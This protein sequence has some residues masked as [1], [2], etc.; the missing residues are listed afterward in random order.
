MAKLEKFREISSALK[1]SY[2]DEW[3]KQGRKIIGY[4]CTYAPEEI[5][6]AA[7]I[8]PY[9]IRGVTCTD[10]SNAD[11]YMARF[12]CSFCR[13]VLELG[14]TGAYDFLDGFCYL[15]GCDHIRRVYDNWVKLV[16]IPFNH[17]LPVPHI[18]SEDGFNYYMEGVKGFKEHIEQHFDMHITDEKLRDSIRVYNESRELLEKLYEF[19]NREYPPVTGA[20]SLSIVAASSAMPRE[21]FNILLG[22]VLKELENMD[23]IRDYDARL[24]IVGSELD[25]PSLIELIED[26]GGL[27]VT[28][29][30]CFGTRQF[31]G[32]VSE[33]G[34]P[35]EAIV[36]RYYEHNPCPR[37]LREYPK[38]LGFV[39]EMAEKFKVDGVIFE[40]IAFCDPHGVDNVMFSKELEEED[41]PTLVL[42]RDYLISDVGRFRTRVQAFLERIGA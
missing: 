22:D 21:E 24:M 20:Q 10:T 17:F 19:R 34:D 16:N 25:H 40:R 37:M 3:K 42:E 28:D 6:H 18:I 31:K 8:M 35:L 41:I 33:E 38:K 39:R 11:V 4:T 27:V 30:L 15:N 12:N 2:V 9:R 1:N 26:L 29:A 32:L 23:G 14:L 36:K 5:I 7:G 13:A